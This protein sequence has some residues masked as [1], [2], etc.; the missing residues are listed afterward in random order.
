MKKNNYDTRARSPWTKIDAGKTVEIYPNTKKLNGTI[1]IPGSKSLTNRALIMSAL[2]NGKSEING[3]L[4]SD[5][6]YWC[7]DSIKKLGVNVEVNDHTV[8]MVGKSGM[9]NSGKLYIGAAGTIA[10]FLP[11]ALAITEG[12]WEIKASERMSKRPVAPLIEALNGIGADIEYMKNSGYY[13]LSIKGKGLKG[14]E[15][16]LSGKI[17]SQFISGLLIASPY[18]K[19]PVTINI[20]DYIVQHSY[21]LLTLKLMEQFGAHV[22]Y[23][24]TLK[25]IIVHP[26]NYLAQ[27]IDLEADAS[28][29]CYFLALAA[30][31]NG[32]IRIDNLSYETQQ[33]DI[34]MVN[35]FEKMG[36]KVTRGKSFIELEGAS[37]LKGGFEISMREMSDQTLTLAAI[38]P[39]TDDPITIRDVAHI[40]HHES[41]RIS[42]ICD[43]LSKMGIEV[44]EFEDGLKVYPGN[45][46]PALLDSYDD[47]RVAMSLALIGSK[48]EG[49][50]ITDP[51]CVS[52]TCPN[53]FELLKSLGMN[54]RLL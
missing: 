16:S 31:T 9:W 19:E 21:V 50:K 10:R 24:N 37:K 40:R 43:S 53:Y 22:E 42:V 41:N 32:R 39:F 11:G 38:A 12:L 1:T 33:P 49:I 44:D 17:S 28:T 46:K 5:D 2:A 26:S 29:A 27:N 7:I 8:H 48:V 30:L 54:I 20:T 45:P 47:H 15:I 52:K 13:P 34:K 3:I 18:A 4:K 25:K 14:G 36:C 51:G 35:V 23:D 6:S